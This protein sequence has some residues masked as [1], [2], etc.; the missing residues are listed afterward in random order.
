MRIAVLSAYLDENPEVL[1]RCHES[2]LGL[3]RADSCEVQ[4]FL[5]ADGHP[6]PDVDSWDAMHI[7]LPA[8]CADKGDTPR[9]VGGAIAYALGFDAVMMLDADNWY[10]P[11]HLSALLDVQQSSQASIVTAT[12]NICG[13]DGE[14]LYVDEDSDGDRYC[15]TNC[16]LIMRSAMAILAKW[17]YKDRELGQVGDRLFWAAVKK[18]TESIARCPVPTICYRAKWATYYVHANQRVPDDAL[19]M[20][21]MNGTASEMKVHEFRAR[22]A[23]GES[24]SCADPA[25]HS[26]LLRNH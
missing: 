17:G 23:R 19:V 18:E 25:V 11:N 6:R 3:R 4:H 15:D 14:F 24:I 2:V 10:L 22:A 21:R 9:A 1:L 16:Y 26:A 20:A 12:R 7:R 8:R 5:I 13:L